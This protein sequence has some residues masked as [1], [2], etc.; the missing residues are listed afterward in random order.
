MHSASDMLV[1]VVTLASIYLSSRPSWNSTTEEIEG[2]G[3]VV[4]GGHGD[5]IERDNGSLGWEVLGAIFINSI[6]LYSGVELFKSGI[7]NLLPTILPFDV[8]LGDRHP[9][10]SHNTTVLPDKHA[11]WFAVLGILVKEGLYRASTSAIPF[12]LLVP[13]PRSLAPNI[14]SSIQKSTLLTALSPSSSH[15]L[16]FH[17]F[18][19][20][21]VDG[22]YIRSTTPP[23]RCSHTPRLPNHNSGS[24]YGLLGSMAGPCGLVN[25]F[26]DGG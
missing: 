7:A 12:A 10:H 8:E 5:A 21:I 19:I 23:H 4:R 20:V 2:P 13:Y 26:G 9:H 22:P 15:I 14:P 18:S 1:D 16:P 17:R 11:A 6:I 25:N 3:I 24:P